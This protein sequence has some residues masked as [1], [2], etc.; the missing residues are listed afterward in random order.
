V[1][2]DLHVLRA[3]MLHEI[4]GE[5]DRVDVVT[6]DGGG[7]LKGLELLEKLA[8]PGGLCHAVDHNAVLSLCA[9]AGDDRLPLGGQET[10]L[11]PRTLHN[12]KWTD[13]CRDSQPS[14]RR[15][16]PRASAS[17]RVG[18]EGRSR[19]SRRGSAGSA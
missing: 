18:V 13:A 19:G 14:Q 8:Q 9:R 17:G 15:C 4:G 6:I 3:L 2:V 12:R 16:R 10:R 7:T 5:V 1:Q 11:R